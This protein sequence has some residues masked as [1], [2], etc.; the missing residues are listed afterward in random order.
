MTIII[1][2]QDS[3]ILLGL[4]FYRVKNFAGS[5]FLM[6]DER[7]WLFSVAFSFV[8]QY[9]NYILLSWKSCDAT[10]ASGA[11]HDSEARISTYTSKVFPSRSKQRTAISQSR[12][13][14]MTVSICFMVGLE[15]DRVTV[16]SEIYP[17]SI[18]FL[19]GKKQPSP[20]PVNKDPR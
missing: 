14:L 15:K 16:G 12:K 18:S 8:P 13:G 2:K 19:V 10:S 7:Q 4:S 6:D 5:L 3:V 20:S 1:N 17:W 9:D 11:K